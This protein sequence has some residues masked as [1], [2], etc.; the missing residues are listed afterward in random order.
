MVNAP[1]IKRKH[2]EKKEIIMKKSTTGLIAIA[3]T[4]LLMSE[5]ANACTCVV[6][7]GPEQNVLTGRTMDFSIDIPANLWI[8]PR[9]MERHGQVGAN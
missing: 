9:G 2:H 1:I 4:C 5:Y 3:M 6:Y 8:F 7:K